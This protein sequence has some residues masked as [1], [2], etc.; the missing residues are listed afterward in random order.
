MQSQVE[1]AAVEK[2]LLGLE[3]NLSVALVSDP[4]PRSFAVEL[5]QVT[6]AELRRTAK[7]VIKLP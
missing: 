4:L 1:A 5:R 3:A 6:L 2:V 7:V